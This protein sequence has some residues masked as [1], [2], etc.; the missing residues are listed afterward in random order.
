MAAADVFVR[1]ELYDLLFDTLDEDT[2]EEILD[3][4]LVNMTEVSVFYIFCSRDKFLYK[5][6]YSQEI[7]CF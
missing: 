7:F 5:N 6:S 2:L 1:G 3:S 4:E